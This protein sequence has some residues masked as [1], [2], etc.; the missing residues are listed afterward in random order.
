MEA[1]KANSGRIEKVCVQRGQKNSRV[2]EIVDLSRA[3]HIPV[4]FEPKEW[5][6]RKSAGQRHQGIL[7]YVSEMPTFSPEDILKQAAS[8]GLLVILDGI[9]DPHNV[10]AILRSA[11]VA[12]ADGV[13]LPQHRSAGLGQVA[14][15]ASAGAASHIRVARVANTA[16]LIESIKKSGYWVAGLDAAAGRPIWEADFRVSTALVLGNEGTGLRRLVKEKCDFLVAIPVRG[17]ISSHNVSVAAGIALYE[18]L[19]QRR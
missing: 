14:V 9:E 15:R 1:L 16:Q 10:G 3:N 5:L 19:R 8:P 17:K 7:C 12:G 13:F 4:T 11:E 2:Q 18:V 6:D